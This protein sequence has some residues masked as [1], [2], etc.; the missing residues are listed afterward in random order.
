MKGVTVFDAVVFPYT[1]RESVNIK[2]RMVPI[3]RKVMA[4][5][6]HEPPSPH[7]IKIF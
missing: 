6:L 4:L 1:G 5:Q 2:E 3:G 7:N